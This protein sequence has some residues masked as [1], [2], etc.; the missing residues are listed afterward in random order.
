MTILHQNNFNAETT[1]ALP[2]GWTAKVGTWA[3]QAAGGESGSKSF[4][5]SPSVDGNAV[6]YTGATARTDMQVQTDNVMLDSATYNSRLPFVSHILRS[7]AAYANCYLCILQDATGTDTQFSA[8]IYKKVGG[9]LSAVTVTAGSALP[10]IPVAGDVYHF[11]SKIV[12]SAISLYVWKN[13]DTEPTTPTFTATDASVTAAGYAGLYNS[14]LSTTAP[15]TADNFVLDDTASAAA[16]FTLTGA[17]AVD[18]F[19]FQRSGTTATASFA[20]TYTGAPT[21][22]QA[23]LVNAGTSTAVTG[24]DWSTK[25][26]SPTGNAFSFSFAS[27]PQGGFYQLQL[28]DSAD[29]GTVTTPSN[30]FGVGKRV[31]PIGQSNIE[32]L[33]MYGTG[34]PN[35]KLRVY[36]RWR[37]PGAWST[38][39]TGAGAIALGNKLITDAGDDV[40][41]ALIQ[42]AVSGAGL[43]AGSGIATTTSGGVARDWLDLTAAPGRPWYDFVTAMNL[44]GPSAEIVIFGQGESD[45]MTAVSPSTYGTDLT[46]LIGRIRTLLGADTKI[47]LPLLGQTN[48][49]TSTDA[50]WELVRQAQIAVASSVANVYLVSKH[51]LVCDA[52]SPDMSQASLLTWGTRLAQKIGDLLGYVT[53]SN[54]PSIASV[55]PVSSTVY[56]INLTHDGGTDIT[57]TAP[58]QIADIRIKDGSTVVTP[59]DIVRQSATKIRFTL[60]SPPSGTL[61]VQSAYGKVP[62]SAN[63]AKD[64]TALALPL[65]A[66]APVTATAL[67]TTVSFAVVDEDGVT[68]ADVSGLDYAFFDQSRISQLQAPVKTG[69]NLSITGGAG[70]INIGGVTTLAPGQT[71]Y[72]Q[73][74]DA[75]GIKS[76]GGPVTVS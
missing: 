2:T 12:G 59:T 15:V 1:G 39:T 40:P 23:R 25:V 19:T 4:G 62:A 26:A 50:N 36:D 29:T 45:A 37:N 42:F 68:I 14:T 35:A 69:T 22:I 48:D 28:R 65:M 66:S 8:A 64:N 18:G 75:A 74:G 49:A 54:G 71:G 16:A 47:V 46:T 34:T 31:I 7:D 53:Y 67:A 10:S 57:P 51:D 33:S 60:A 21:S 41:V 30:V 20:G 9:S 73:W 76:G 17:T 11:K 72:I 70:S 44:I 58:T 6:L 63:V 5:C 55:T 38:T 32:T 24:F 27:V 13:S 43:H 3:V 56:D 61:T 52:G